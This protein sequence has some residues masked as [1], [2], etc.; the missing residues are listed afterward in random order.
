MNTVYAPQVAMRMVCTRV[1]WSVLGS[2]RHAKG[3][4]R[5]KILVVLTAMKSGTAT[6]LSGM[7]EQFLQSF[8]QTARWIVYDCSAGDCFLT[9]GTLADGH[10]LCACGIHTEVSASPVN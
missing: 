9:A 1:A 5:V 6:G 2:R 8:W 4:L 3:L 7:G 10:E